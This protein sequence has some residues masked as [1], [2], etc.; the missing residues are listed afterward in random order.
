MAGAAIL[1]SVTVI[2]EERLVE[3]AE[4]VGASC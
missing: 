1:A 2:E 4:K 3:N